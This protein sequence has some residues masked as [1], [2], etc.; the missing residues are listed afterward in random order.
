MEAF[1]RDNIEK[2]WKDLID[3]T[4]FDDLWE[5]F[6]DGHDDEIFTDSIIK[7]ILSKPDNSQRNECFYSHITNCSH[8]LAYNKLI[9]SLSSSGHNHLSL[10]VMKNKLLN[11]DVDGLDGGFNSKH[12]SETPLPPKL[13]NLTISRT[14]TDT[15][16]QKLRRRDPELCYLLNS[17]PPGYLLLINNEFEYNHSE[18]RLGSEVDV[19]HLRD[20]FTQF[21]FHIVE[22][23]NL[24]LQG[25]EEV[26]DKFSHME[27]LCNVDCVF[28]FIMSHGRD[29][30]E[31][32][33][34]DPPLKSP[35]RESV[36]IELEDNKHINSND[37][38]EQI[39]SS[40]TIRPNTPKLFFFNTCRGKKADLGPDR[41]HSLYID[42]SIADTSTE[43]DALPV[44]THYQNGNSNNQNHALGYNVNHKD[45]LPGNHSNNNDALPGNH[46]NNNDALLGNHS[47]N[48][49]ALLGNHSN[50][51]DAL[52]G[53]HS[54][55]NDAPSDNHALG[56]NSNKFNRI[57]LHNNVRVT[58]VSSKLECYLANVRKLGKKDKKNN[59]LVRCATWF[60]K[61]FNCVVPSC[62]KYRLNTRSGADSAD[63]IEGQYAMDS[64][65]PPQIMKPPIA[66]TISSNKI[67]NK[68]FL[69]G[70]I[71]MAFSTVYGYNSKRHPTHGSWFVANLCEVFAE[72]AKDTDLE[73]MMEEVDRRMRKMKDRKYGTQMYVKKTEGFSKKFYFNVKLDIKE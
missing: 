5:K 4:R 39:N 13:E 62:S 61:R 3:Q 14:P 46:S 2:H 27:E 44:F 55:N 37:I 25:I 9:Q 28:V 35:G 21:G 16:L 34:Q 63:S 6:R 65:L 47:N 66:P 41:D 71:F 60:S 72:K 1:H 18:T 31:R 45:A 30:G 24:T 29:P 20:L 58:D 69:T 52:P 22:R 38:V 40:S 53:N 49:D 23:H 17:S 64:E 73:T 59:R 42:G 32:K 57:S 26:L 36:D 54:N 48:N 33:P 50:N 51:N 15:C 43:I 67:K 7:D 12:T 10:L 56:N 8:H 68:K 70:D 11:H 19:K